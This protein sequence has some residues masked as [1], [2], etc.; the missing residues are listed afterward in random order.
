MENKLIKYIVLIFIIAITACKREKL[1]E[2]A[3][4]LKGRWTWIHT[5][6]NLYDSG[7]FADYQAA[8]FS[9]TYSI[10]IYTKGIDFLVNGKKEISRKF[11]K[12]SVINGDTDTSRIYIWFTLTKDDAVEIT[13]FPTKDYFVTG[14]FPYEYVLNG[15]INVVPEG[16]GYWNYFKRE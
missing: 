2:N 9:D 4:F 7:T 14:G 6:K 13:Y 8:S 10:E 12:I 15:S 16:N 1:P 11:K 5:Y 3:A